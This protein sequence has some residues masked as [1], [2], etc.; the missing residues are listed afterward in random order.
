VRRPCPN[1]AYCCG[2]GKKK[3]NNFFVIFEPEIKITDSP[4]TE[5]HV[6]AD[7]Q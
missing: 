4:S 1:V 5:M 6:I 7:R 3:Q 2:K